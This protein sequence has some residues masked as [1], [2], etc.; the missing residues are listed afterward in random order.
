MKRFRGLC[1]FLILR[2]VKVFILS[3]ATVHRK[4]RNK[5]SNTNS[6][7]FSAFLDLGPQIVCNLYA[8][9]NKNIVAPH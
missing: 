9:K 3:A 2:K 8:N 7:N 4:K 6:G 5:R 1:S